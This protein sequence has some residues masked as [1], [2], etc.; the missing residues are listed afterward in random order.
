[1]T[2]LA[3]QARISDNP[4]LI[5]TL[6]ETRRRVSA[7]ALVHR[8]LYR[9]NQIKSLDAALYIEELCAD[10]LAFMGRDWAQ[11]L[12]LNVSPVMISADRAVI[13]GLLLTEL[14]INVAKHA[15]GGRVGP[16]EIELIEEG[17]LLRLTV[18]D[19][20]VGEVSHSKGFGL[21]IIRGLAAQL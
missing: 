2:F 17:A 4:E 11:H 9:D 7:V 6:K 5:A 1:S 10:T 21:V 20:G 16:I 18:A 19:R 3:L 13:L 14:M 12:S 15:Y 8:R